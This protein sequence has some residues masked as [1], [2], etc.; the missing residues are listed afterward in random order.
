VAF[1]RYVRLAADVAGV[2]V[3]L[4]GA[5]LRDALRFER[6]EIAITQRDRESGSALLACCQF[7]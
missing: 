1:R 7:G 3:H 5:A 6:E 2:A 4:L